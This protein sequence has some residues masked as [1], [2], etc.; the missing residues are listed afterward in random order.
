MKAL[1]WPQAV[2][3][4]TVLLVIAALVWGDKN[5]GAL[6]TAAVAILGALGLLVKGQAE[7]K[8]RTD[9][10]QQQTNGNTRELL[11]MLRDKDTQLAALQTQHQADLKEMA[12]KLAEMQPPVVAAPAVD[13]HASA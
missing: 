11:A 6:V 10:V 2:V 1:N 7:V 5:T 12:H 3:A 8:E 9:A 13:E 4:A